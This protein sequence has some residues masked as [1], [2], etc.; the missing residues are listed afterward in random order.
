MTTATTAAP[1]TI[2]NARPRPLG[3]Q[4]N[5]TLY[6]LAEQRG[7]LRDRFQNLSMNTKVRGIFGTFLLLLVLTVAVAAI[8][9]GDIYVR[10]NQFADLTRFHRQFDRS[11]QS[12]GRSAI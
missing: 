1:A 7:R 9:M 2:E 11:A 6:R 12:D 3:E 8:G 4:A 10:Y 5:D